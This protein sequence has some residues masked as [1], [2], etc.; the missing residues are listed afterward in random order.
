MKAIRLPNSAL[1]DVFGRP[2]AINSH[3]FHRPSYFEQFDK[4]AA[5]NHYDAGSKTSNGTN[6]AL[7]PDSN[8]RLAVIG[9]SLDRSDEHLS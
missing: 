5:N 1:L 2:V 9:E 4:P 8:H 7:K 3:D 6:P